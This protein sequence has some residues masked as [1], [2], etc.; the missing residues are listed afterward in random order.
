VAVADRSRRSGI[1]ATPDDARA[2]RKIHFPFAV[3]NAAGKSRGYREGAEGG[4]ATP[5]CARR[6]SGAGV[7]PAHG[8]GA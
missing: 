5:R 8:W 4:T 2:S 3:A 1:D 6:P 7:P